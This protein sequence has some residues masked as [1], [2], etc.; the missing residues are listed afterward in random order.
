MLFQWIS[1]L[2]D[3]MFTSSCLSLYC[4]CYGN[5]ANKYFNLFFCCPPS[6][7]SV[8][9]LWQKTF[10][11]I[12]IKSKTAN[13][14]VKS[15]FTC[16]WFNTYPLFQFICA[17]HFKKLWKIAFETHFRLIYIHILDRKLDA[18]GNFKRQVFQSRSL[19]K[20]SWKDDSTPKDPLAPFWECL[21]QRS[22]L[23][24]ILSNVRKTYF[25]VSLPE[26]VKRALISLEMKDRKC[27]IKKVWEAYSWHE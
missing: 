3:E 4:N 15:F 2:S 27:W 19:W 9:E 7:L 14:K 6:K 21:S 18:Y 23:P 8:Q 26:R 1:T 16:F 11:I 25:H 12:L 24:S 13:C 5:S 10:C 17:A 22:C 20:L